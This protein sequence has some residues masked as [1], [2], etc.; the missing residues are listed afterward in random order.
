[1][2]SVHLNDAF[3]S[4]ASISPLRSV[5]Q[6]EFAKFSS[7]LVISFHAEVQKFSEDWPDLGAVIGL[8]VR[9]RTICLRPNWPSLFHGRR[10]R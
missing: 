7:G 2:P 8:M 4:N 6:P 5:N 3:S 10:V 1:V 9:V